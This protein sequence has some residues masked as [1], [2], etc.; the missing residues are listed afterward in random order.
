MHTRDGNINLFVH[1]LFIIHLHT[2]L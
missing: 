1:H 2:I